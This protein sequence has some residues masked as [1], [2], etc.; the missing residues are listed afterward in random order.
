VRLAD[1]WKAEEKFAF[2]PLAEK[3][4]RRLTRYAKQD[5]ANRKIGRNTNKLILPNHKKNKKLRSLK[6]MSTSISILGNTGRDVELRYTPQGTAVASFS[7]ASNSVR[8][9]A[10][11]K[12]KKTDWY[13]V[14]A[15]GRQAETLAK[16]LTKGSQILV[17][18]KLSFNPWLS[19]D[20][21]ARVSAEV[22]M[23][24]FEFAG[25]NAAKAIGEAREEAIPAE[26]NDQAFGRENISTEDAEDERAEIMAAVHEMDVTDEAF[27]G[28]F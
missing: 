10:Q 20:G 15:F 21:E 14:S 27:A 11:G 17:R 6:I 7:I 5:L 13:N 26:E 9:T 28:Q 12:Q 4:K 25:G 2:H 22:V 8:N 1:E 16:Y 23:Q 3:E 18:G 24:D 19:R